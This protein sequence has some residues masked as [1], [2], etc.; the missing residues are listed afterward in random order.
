MTVVEGVMGLYDGVDGVSELA[1]T[2]QVAKALRAPVI[3]VLNGERANR[4]LRAV[5]RGLKEFD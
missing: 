3:L 2:A 5:V 4:T 1:S